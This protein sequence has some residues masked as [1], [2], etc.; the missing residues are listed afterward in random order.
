MVKNCER[1]PFLMKK[2]IRN[3][4]IISYSIDGMS[5]MCVIT[6]FLIYN[7]NTNYSVY[8]QKYIQMILKCTKIINIR[9]AKTG[10][11]EG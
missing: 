11:Y 3:L 7:K 2:I 10:L 5:K 6:W 9:M 4:L 1:L 8:I